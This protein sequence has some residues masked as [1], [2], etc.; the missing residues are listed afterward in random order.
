MVEAR[1][2]LARAEQRAA[3]ALTQL[4]GWD[5][6]AEALRRLAVPLDATVDQFESR[7]Q[8]IARKRQALSERLSKETES[9][10][11]CQAGLQ[12]LGLQQDVPTEE[13]MAAARLYRQEGWRLIKAHWLENA[14]DDEATVAFLAAFA[15][16]GSLA[17][18]YEQSV[19]RADSLADRLRREADRVARNA[20]LL[21]ALEKHRAA[22]AALE[23]DLQALDQLQVAIERDWTA[24][25]ATLGISAE[26]QAPTELRAWL[27]RREE[28][29]QLV[30]LADEARQSVAPLD[31]VLA[32]H[33][34]AL[35]QALESCG[36]PSR[37]ACRDLAES[38][39]IAEALLKEQDGLVQK[40]LQ[41]E[42][43]LAD[44]RVEQA[45][46]RLSLQSAESELDI[47]H[48]D[49]SARMSRIGLEAGAAPE[50]AEIILNRIAELLTVLDERGDFQARISGIDRDA[51]QFRQDVSTMAQRVALD[52]ADW[53]FK[54]Q[55]RELAAR[56]RRAQA[57]AKQSAVMAAQRRQE[58]AN[59]QAAEAKLEEAQLCLEHLRQEAKCKELT[60]L[61]E[62]E[63][64]SQ[65]RV[66]LE[67]Q[68]AAAKEQLMMNAAGDDLDSFA[69]LAERADP[70]A[71]DASIAELDGRISALEEEL[72]GIEQ[73]IGAARTALSQMNGRG[74]AAE[75]AENIQT[76]LVSLQKDVTRFATLKLATAVLNR[77]VERYR[78]KNQGSILARAGE[79]FAKLTGGSFTRLTID[80]D[81]GSLVLKG[82]RPDGRLVG[83]KGM[84]D[85]SHNQLY[86]ALRLA[87][88]ESWLHS[89][90]PIPFIVDDIL[91]TFDDQRATAAMGALAELSRKTQVLFF[92]HHR[93][94]V[95][96]ARIH[97]PRD[98]VFIHELPGPAIPPS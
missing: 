58:E 16:A 20:T 11:E 63:L 92:T 46:A 87:S 5:Q 57:D 53:P 43:K 78:E 9:I 21:A 90:E 38:L 85:G 97:I 95:D 14:P 41:L 13:A 93:H 24:L 10:R 75:T 86:L 70:S 27:G 7:F 76:L 25:V 80:D 82:I 60:Q 35:S 23:H 29:A 19:Q 36:T 79:L 30:E 6:S 4:P 15:P 34:L 69:S 72:R 91:L 39:E 18:A 44:L 94:L 3:L 33:R 88:L 62:A 49:W 28:I 50:Q 59:V 55:T 48:R 45:N 61:P 47:W 66:H 52:I 84:S 74:D 64:R 8:E 2:K 17:A 68:L 96:L 26:V 40:R 51:H 98:L 54:E 12:S 89:H 22:Q 56:L 1:S 67:S 32:S 31:Q 71:I 83:V 42:S 73:K 65:N 81:D 37:A 77:A